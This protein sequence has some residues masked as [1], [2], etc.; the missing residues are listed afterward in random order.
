MLSIQMGH[1]TLYEMCCSFL[2]WI[3]ITGFTW[4]NYYCL[5]VKYC[6]NIRQPQ[7]I[8]E[9]TADRSRSCRVRRQVVRASVSV[10]CRLIRSVGLE[11]CRVAPL[12]DVTRCLI[13]ADV[14]VKL[15]LCDSVEWC[16][17]Q[18]RGCCRGA[19]PCPCRP[20][21]CYRTPCSA[22]PPHH[23]P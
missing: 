22:S 10:P 1:T 21:T 8:I 14:D 5:Q 6:C 13:D 3:L 16:S 11:P 7:L 17:T 18:G 23:R 20:R 15:V 19:C 2:R 4:D 12:C 9:R